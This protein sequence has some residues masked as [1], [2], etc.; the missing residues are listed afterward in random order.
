M[1]TAWKL[2]QTCRVL[3]NGGVVAY[4]TETVYGLGCDPDDLLAVARLLSI[5]R[6]PFGKGLILLAA[7]W[8]QLKPYVAS[9]SKDIKKRIKTGDK[10]PVTWL[11]PASERAPPWI[12][13]EHDT[14]AVR[15]TSHPQTM[16]LLKAF[17]KPL[18][19]TSAN[20][21]RQ[22]PCR[23]TTQVQHRF[24]TELDAI[25]SGTSGPF[26]KPSEIRDAATGKVVRKS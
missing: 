2:K 26:R 22:S 23:N 12:S 3:H 8:K 11:V 20:L 16:R 21:N 6:R 14:I 13:G 10:K 15:I 1:S 7:D 17:G 5:K 18:V 24:G 25:V 9:L 4:P 19:S